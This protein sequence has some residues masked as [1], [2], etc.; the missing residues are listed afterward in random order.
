MPGRGVAPKAVRSRGRDSAA[1]A[2]EMTQVADTGELH[3]PELPDDAIS[4]PWHPM[5]IRLWETLRGNPMLVD[6]PDLDWQF[7]ID[8]A[9][10]HHIMWATGKFTHAQEIRL[11]LAKFGA[12]PEDRMR[13]KMQIVTPSDA[14]PAPIRPADESLARRRNLRIAE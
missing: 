13:L 9:L 10:M 12:T 2:A 7:L 3:G 1:R 11:R 6:L 8:T 4:E 5:T 14:N